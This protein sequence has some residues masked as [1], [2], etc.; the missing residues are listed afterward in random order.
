MTVGHWAMQPMQPMQCAVY[1]AQL[2]S[3]WCCVV[4]NCAENMMYSLNLILL[5]EVWLF[6]F[7]SFLIFCILGYNKAF[8]MHFIDQ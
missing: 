1:S 5:A 7:F 4:C 2:C 8:L 3:L 6:L